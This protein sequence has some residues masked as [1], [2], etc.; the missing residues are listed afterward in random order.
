MIV[1]RKL[2][3][4][5]TEHRDLIRGGLVF[6]LFGIIYY[7]LIQF[8]SFRIPCIFYE[9]TGWYCAGC[10]LSRFALALIQFDVQKAIHQNACAALLIPIWMI[11]GIIE[12]V[13]NPRWLE[14]DRVVVKTLIVFSFLFAVTF[15]FLR[16]L[17]GL[18]IL[19]PL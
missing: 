18:E 14:S 19:A 3:T 13:W 2:N 16:N 9:R 12:L 17:P 11:L 15:G 4:F 8:T 1:R 6:A 7:L 5:A 10:G